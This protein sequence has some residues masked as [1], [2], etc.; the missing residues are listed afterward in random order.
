ML[1]KCHT[2]LMPIHLHISQYFQGILSIVLQLWH[3]QCTKILM[4]TTS[5]ITSSDEKSDY[6]EVVLD[7]KEGSVEEHKLQQIS[8]E[9][10]CY[11]YV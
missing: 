3:H 4:F 5:H 6:K 1:N 9:P 8:A 7:Y 10:I 2:L 11:P